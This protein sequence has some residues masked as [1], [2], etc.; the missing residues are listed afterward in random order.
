MPAMHSLMVPNNGA[1]LTERQPTG[2]P[3][4]YLRA[5]LQDA[6]PLASGSRLIARGRMA[7]PGNR[8]RLASQIARKRK[9]P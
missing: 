3:P 2:Y 4:D 1:V 6:Y 9:P 7:L 5:C 8:F